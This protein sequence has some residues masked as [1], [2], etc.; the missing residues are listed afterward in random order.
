MARSQRL[1][2]RGNLD[3]ALNVEKYVRSP[4]PAL[5]TDTHRRILTH[6]RQK[7]ERLAPIKNANKER[8][9]RWLGVRG[10]A[11]AKL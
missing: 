6:E 4:V 9:G 2:V 3:S 11:K 8:E 10:P 5:G 1:R 7:L